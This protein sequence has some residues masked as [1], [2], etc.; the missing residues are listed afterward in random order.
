MRHFLVLTSKGLNFVTGW[1]GTPGRVPTHVTKLY[2][3][4]LRTASMGGVMSLRLAIRMGYS[5]KVIEEA[6][7]NAYVKLT[8]VPSKPEKE[9]LKRIQDMVGEPP[10]EIYV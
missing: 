8:R 7:S 1:F 3:F 9:V 4:L 2:Q 6:V 10:K 5:R